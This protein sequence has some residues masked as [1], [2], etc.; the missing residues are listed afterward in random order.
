MKCNRKKFRP[1]FT[2]IEIALALLVL[3]I[4]LLAV[5]GL[6]PV[7]IDSNRMALG[8]TRA[9]MF[10]EE[11]L[12]GVRARAALFDWNNIAGNI[13]LEPPSPN[14]W[15]EPRD[16]RIRVVQNPDPEHFD[17]IIYRASGFR[18]DRGYEDFAIRYR[19]EID[20]INQYSKAVRLKVR[21]GRFGSTNTYVFYTEIYNYG[22]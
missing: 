14:M 10:G 21:P 18:S 8:E 17:T 16:M 6:F 19:L 22:R 13:I 11:V 3:S 20:N 1:G 9:A 12:N 7:G 15:E 5:F 2:L 4:G